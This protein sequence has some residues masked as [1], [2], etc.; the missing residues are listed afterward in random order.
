MSA[1]PPYSFHSLAL[2][3]M[4][5]TINAPTILWLVGATVARLTPDQKAGG[6]NP[7]LVIVAAAARNPS[8]VIVFALALAFAAGGSHAE[9]LTGHRFRVRFCFCGRRQPR[10]IPHWSFVAPKNV[11]WLPLGS[12]AESLLRPETSVRVFSPPS[13]NSDLG[14]HDARWSLQAPSRRL[15]GL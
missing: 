13:P 1:C 11:C 15:Y 6:S 3:F 10:G 7:S 9:S 2:V 8:L 12:A 5:T 4:R 14:R